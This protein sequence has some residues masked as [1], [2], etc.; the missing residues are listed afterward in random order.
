MI[1]FQHG[2]FWFDHSIGSK[3]SIFLLL[4]FPSARSL[5]PIEKRILDIKTENAHSLINFEKS[6]QTQHHQWWK[7]HNMIQILIRKHSP[8]IPTYAIKKGEN[9][10]HL[11][12]N[13]ETISSWQLHG[14]KTLPTV[15]T[16][17]P[18]KSDEEEAQSYDDTWAVKKNK[19]HLCYGPVATIKIKQIS[20]TLTSLGPGNWSKFT[21]FLLPGLLVVVVWLFHS[22]LWIFLKTAHFT[23]GWF[24]IFENRPIDPEFSIVSKCEANVSKKAKVSK[25]CPKTKK[26]YGILSLCHFF[27]IVSALCEDTGILTFSTKYNLCL[28]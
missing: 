11:V 13:F 2:G 8:Y 9:T 7:Y 17:R 18:C 26:W 16:W 24:R 21:S 22:E 12:K 4:R 6:Y 25:K 15:T 10:L 1:I 20:T 27:P 14:S 3:N 28:N 19:H 5:E 23:F